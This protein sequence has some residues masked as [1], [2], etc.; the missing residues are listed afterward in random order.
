MQRVTLEA[1]IEAITVEPATRDSAQTLHAELSR[2]QTDLIETD[3]GGQQVRIEIGRSNRE[4]IGVLNAIDEYFSRRSER[5]PV[6]IL[7]G[8]RSY[9]LFPSGSSRRRHV[10]Y[11]ELRTP[12]AR[13]RV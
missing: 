5:P 3:D 9:R 13:G 1:A 6:R 7:F 10:R 4:L 11:A 8:G 12:R 2:F